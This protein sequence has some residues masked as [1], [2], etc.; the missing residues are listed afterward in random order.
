MKKAGYSL[1]LILSAVFLSSCISTNISHA[2]S[3]SQSYF[4][5]AWTDSDLRHVA[6]SLI[7]DC[8][9]STGVSNYKSQADELPRVIIG[10]ITNKSDGHVDTSKLIRRLQAALVNSGAMKL[11]SSE[12]SQACE[13]FENLKQAALEF[14]VDFIL[15]GT[16]HSKTENKDNHHISTYLIDM[17]LLDIQNDCVLWQGVSDDIK[18][19][20]SGQRI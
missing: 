6:E 12:E 19:R 3:N 15:Q 1:L 18:K 14:G 7:Q 20:S 5:E 16:I 9:N 17:Q 8:V 10:K 13:D 11:T 2:D 4:S